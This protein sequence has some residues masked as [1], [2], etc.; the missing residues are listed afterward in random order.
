M[1]MFPE[2]YSLPK[3]SEEKSGNLNSPINRSEIECVI[4]ATT[5]ITKTK[6]Q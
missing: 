1:D 4:K 2:T 3:L 5:T 6:P